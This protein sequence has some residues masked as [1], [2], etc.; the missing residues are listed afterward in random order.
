MEERTY[1]QIF[2]LGPLVYLVVTLNLFSSASGHDRP[3]Y[4]ATVLSEGLCSPSL[5]FTQILCS[6]GQFSLH[7]PGHSKSTLLSNKASLPC[8]WARTVRL[9][10]SSVGDSTVVVSPIVSLCATAFIMIASHAFRCN[11]VRHLPLEKNGQHING[12]FPLMGFWASKYRR[13]QSMQILHSHGKFRCS[14]SSARTSASKQRRH[15]VLCSASSSS[16]FIISSSS[17]S[18]DL[19]S[20]S[21]SVVAVPSRSISS[22][23]FLV[24]FLGSRFGAFG[25]FPVDRST[26]FAF[27]AGNP[28]SSFFS[29]FVVSLCF[30]AAAV[31]AT[32][33]SLGSFTSA[34]VFSTSPSSEFNIVM[35][36]D[37]SSLYSLISSINRSRRLRVYPSALFCS[38]VCIN[39]NPRVAH[40][41]LPLGPLW[42]HVSSR[43][44]Q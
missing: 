39:P 44:P 17:S 4:T 25:V 28:G 14:G 41:L 23:F 7:S 42:P 31:A 6:C 8:L 13:K 2:R 26:I 15:T 43:I 33:Y 32:V 19:S 38:K 35:H 1:V 30:A 5:I 36:I 37:I 27:S 40:D 20:D 29:F 22:A 10:G 12:A 11:D 24:L 3:L 21:P 34:F 9:S 18:L 16:F